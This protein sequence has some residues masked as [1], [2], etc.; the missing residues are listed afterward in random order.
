MLRSPSS[1][2]DVFFNFSLSSFTSDNL[3]SVVD[4]EITTKNVTEILLGDLEMFLGWNRGSYRGKMKFSIVSHNKM[5]SYVNPDLT[6]YNY[7]NCSKIT[8]IE[9]TTDL[10]WRPGYARV[11]V[12]ARI[13]EKENLD[14]YKHILRV[15]LLSSKTNNNQLA[16]AIGAC[17]KLN[18]MNSD[19]IDIKVHNVSTPTEFNP[20]ISG[21]WL[22]DTVDYYVS[23]MNDI[24][25]PNY[26]IYNENG[27]TRYYKIF[28]R[29]VV[30]SQNI[31]A[32]DGN[33][34]QY[35]MYED[36]S[37]DFCGWVNCP[38]NI[39]NIITVPNGYNIPGTDIFISSPRNTPHT[40]RR[41]DGTHFG[42]TTSE[43]ETVSV[44]GNYRYKRIES[45]DRDSYNVIPGPAS[46][47]QRQ[48]KLKVFKFRN[49]SKHTFYPSFAA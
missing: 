46:A 47:I 29:N 21:M 10:A 39:E 35:R 34:W 16:Y 43:T 49:I 15:Y 28:V 14:P 24:N 7:D 41:I 20:R 17:C 13:Q 33:S 32:N 45:F 36:G 30:C 27:F 6:L 26:N 4:I 8:L 42:I 22:G 31:A 40:F 25:Y 38:A 23:N 11:F 9:D 19:I 12:C 3:P 44:Y 48:K 2:K 1:V 18:V 5:F 37:Y